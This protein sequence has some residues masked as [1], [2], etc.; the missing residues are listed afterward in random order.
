MK[1]KY[2]FAWFLFALLFSGCSPISPIDEEAIGHVISLDEDGILE[3]IK[4]GEK[5]APVL[6]DNGDKNYEKHFEKII[7]GIR[8]F[9]PNGDG[10]IEVLIYVHGGLNTKGTSLK[11]VQEKYKLIRDSKNEKKYPIFVNWRSGPLTTYGSHLWRIRQGEISSTAPLTSPVYL[12]TDVGNSLINA[13]KA[14][15][16]TGEHSWRASYSR[17]DKYLEEYPKG[18]NLV[19]F[20]NNTGEYARWGR[21]LWWLI[22]SPAKVVTTP[23]TYTMAK[24]AWDIMLRRTNTPFY[25]P[26]DLANVDHKVDEVIKPGTG[27]LGIFLRQLA[28]AIKEDTKKNKPPVKI[29]LVGHSMGA[30]IVNKIIN[31]EIDLPYENIVHMASADSINNLFEQVVPYLS[32]QAKT[33]DPVNFYSLSLHPENED[34]ERSAGG[35]TPS[36]SLLVWIDSMFTTPETV[37]DKRSGRWEN[38][39]RAIRLLPESARAKMHFKIFS[40]NDDGDKENGFITEPQKHGQFGDLA[41]WL[42]STWWK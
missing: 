28:D 30:I 33:D 39:E 2:W 38:M 6:S 20:T 23:F 41:F 1:I 37:M 42:E 31:Q 16:I 34:R 11:R 3:S 7:D 40:L 26:A 5:I 27:A 14:W 24:P 18:N 22:T 36:G 21:S 8:A 10:D 17:D 15:L 35:L 19:Y 13:P 32:A 29:T 25:T 4:P 12:S 9:S